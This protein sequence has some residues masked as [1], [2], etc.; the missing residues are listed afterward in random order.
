MVGE[1]QFEA[2]VII[3]NATVY[4]D[5]AQESLVYEVTLE[6][7]KMPD[8]Q[9]SFVSFFV[10]SSIG[11]SSERSNANAAPGYECD[12]TGVCQYSSPEADVSKTVCIEFWACPTE[13]FPVAND[14]TV[15]ITDQ[16]VARIT[17]SSQ[18]C[19]NDQETT[20]SGT[21]PNFW[22]AIP[23]SYSG[24]HTFLTCPWRP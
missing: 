19:T 11:T 2:E 16:G 23:Y 17:E 12:D 8:A 24:Y 14:P 9:M 1:E 22:G 10:D 5:G 7:G 15:R 13:P 20:I 3:N 4:A 21:I 18:A 6:A